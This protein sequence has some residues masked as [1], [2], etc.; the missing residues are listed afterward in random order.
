M[1]C[2]QNKMKDAKLAARNM[3]KCHELQTIASLWH[4][5]SSVH[6]DHMRRGIRTVLSAQ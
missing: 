5:L 6:V 4:P 1:I 3:K 2:F